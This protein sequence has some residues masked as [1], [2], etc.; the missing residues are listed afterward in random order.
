M[1]PASVS[2]TPE[3]SKKRRKKKD[4][5]EEEGESIGEDDE[6]EEDQ[7]GQEEDDEDEDFN[8]SNNDDNDE[9][10][11]DSSSS[12]DEHDEEIAREDADAIAEA[13]KIVTS[14]PEF[15]EYNW[16]HAN[17]Y[18]IVKSH[19][20]PHPI[21][22]PSGL[23][24][25]ISIDDARV[26]MSGGNYYSRGSG[27]LYNL[28]LRRSI[29]VDD[30]KAEI[31]RF[32]IT[33]ARNSDE[34]GICFEIAWRVLR[35]VPLSEFLAPP[36]RWSTVPI[37][38]PLAANVDLFV[39]LWTDA[40]RLDQNDSYNTRDR[41][42][43]MYYFQM[44]IEPWIYAERNG[45]QRAAGGAPVDLRCANWF[46][47]LMY[48]YTFFYTGI[49]ARLFP[50]AG[51]VVP[52]GLIASDYTKERELA[53]F[54]DAQTRLRQMFDTYVRYSLDDKSAL[55]FDELSS[56]PLYQ[57]PLE[58]RQARPPRRELETGLCVQIDIS[59]D[60]QTNEPVIREI[61]VLNGF[62]CAPNKNATITRLWIS[63][64]FKDKRIGDAVGRVFVPPTG[65]TPWT[66]AHASESKEWQKFAESTA[67]VGISLVV[68]SVQMP[69]DPNESARLRRPL[70]VS[71]G[72]TR[73]TLPSRTILAD[74]PELLSPAFV[75][76]G[77]VVVYFAYR[78][79]VALTQGDV[80]DIL[81]AADRVATSHHLSFE[82]GPREMRES[83][84][85]VDTTSN[86]YASYNKLIHAIVNDA[87]LP[88]HALC[89]NLCRSL[90]PDDRLKQSTATSA[91]QPPS[92]DQGPVKFEDRIRQT[93]K[94]V[95]PL[96]N[97]YI[98]AY[99]SSA[100]T[101][102]TVDVTD[103]AKSE[104]QLSSAGQNWHAIL[105]A[106]MQL[107]TRRIV[108]GIPRTFPEKKTDLNRIVLSTLA[109]GPGAFDD[110]EL[111]KTLLRQGLV[112]PPTIDTINNAADPLQVA[113]RCL[114]I[115]LLFEQPAIGSH[116]TFMLR[117]KD[118]KTRNPVYRVGAEGVLPLFEEPVPESATV[119]E[120]QRFSTA[121]KGEGKKRL[122]S[123]IEKDPL[124]ELNRTVAPEVLL[125]CFVKS[126]P[127]PK[128]REVYQAKEQKP[129]TAAAAAK[130]EQERDEEEERRDRNDLLLQKAIAQKAK[131]RKNEKQQNA[132]ESRVTII[133]KINTIATAAR[134]RMFEAVRKKEKAMAIH[135]A[136]QRHE[137]NIKSI[138]NR[139]DL[140]RDTREIVETHYYASI[141]DPLQY[142]PAAFSSPSIWLDQLKKH[143]GTDPMLSPYAIV[144]TAMAAASAVAATSAVL[145]E[146][147]HTKRAL[148]PD[149]D[150]GRN[151]IAALRASTPMATCVRIITDIYETFNERINWK[152][153]PNYSA[154]VENRISDRLG[155]IGSS[156]ASVA[157]TAD[158]SNIV[159]NDEAKMLE[160]QRK[161]T[162]ST[163]SLSL[164][165]GSGGDVDYQSL[166]SLADATKSI[167]A[168]ERKIRPFFY[169]LAIELEGIESAKTDQKVRA[170]D[171]LITRVRDWL[172][173]PRAREFVRANE[174]KDTA[175]ALDDKSYELYVESTVG[176]VRRG[177]SLPGDLISLRAVAQLYLVRIVILYR[178]PETTQEGEAR[179][180][181]LLGKSTNRRFSDEELAKAVRENLI[182]PVVILPRVLQSSGVS[183]VENWY[184]TIYV[185]ALACTLP[186]KTPNA[187]YPSFLKDTVQVA[188]IPMRCLIPK[189][190]YAFDKLVAQR[191][192]E[193]ASANENIIRTKA[194]ESA[195]H[196]F[197]NALQKA[198]SARN[199]ASNDAMLVA[200]KKGATANPTEDADR[201][202]ILLTQGRKQA[203]DELIPEDDG[204]N[205]QS[206][207]RETAVSIRVWVRRPDLLFSTSP[208][209]SFSGSVNVDY[210]Y[211][212]IGQSGAASFGMGDMPQDIGLDVYDP[213]GFLV[214]SGIQCVRIRARAIRHKSVPVNR[215]AA[216][217]DKEKRA[218]SI[219]RDKTTGIALRDT[220]REL[221]PL[222]AI[223]E[224]TAWY[225]LL[226]RTNRGTETAALPMPLDTGYRGQSAYQALLEPEFPQ[227]RENVSQYF[228]RLV[229]LEDFYDSVY[230]YDKKLG[231]KASADNG[232]GED[233]DSS[234]SS[235]SSD[236]SSSSSSSSDVVAVAA[237]PSAQQHAEQGR[238]PIISVVIPNAPP[239]ASPPKQATKGSSGGSFLGAMQAKLGPKK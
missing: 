220:S 33:E 58:I 159:R 125:E 56:E 204:D 122:L 211:D 31:P 40:V 80:Y 60:R 181:A 83:V 22:G 84:G 95:A 197:T 155:F 141:K 52:R 4:E 29:R 103:D 169:T 206:D 171:N 18:L 195:K 121:L 14:G 137:A 222:Q 238:K 35:Y 186:S 112:T 114:S 54:P 135:A 150:V 68:D 231:K 201:V 142:A 66:R 228:N 1:L 38:N 2:V 27:R 162:T 62:S 7:E 225:S 192:I 198:A 217:Y 48:Y 157:V 168:D 224:R 75:K 65:D 167:D 15:Q 146:R 133:D 24:H 115:D 74:H 53:T 208:E 134:N 151:A 23:E 110:D 28:Y 174:L 207:K 132:T 96:S 199:I 105:D 117:N 119:V 79:P 158:V 90:P 57:L 176:T 153:E 101:V 87:K 108:C 55:S 43:E 20:I 147:T 81:T 69:V 19:A 234:S 214:R 47:Q 71:L 10:D 184:R 8:G 226:A 76:G 145:L 185:S 177:W 50:G 230:T 36:S 97:A 216:Y 59:T 209:E 44:F 140:S 131:Q 223:S 175:F 49:R 39:E 148:V 63:V 88:V 136:T 139:N 219:V 46:D 126:D 194:N 9:S 130:A 3:E 164:S 82:F 160:Q 86:R 152:T 102:T 113:S 203:E 221:T 16:K 202:K 37:A 120:H 165:S 144:E 235:D 188:W 70:S 34:L 190:S 116:T 172:L 5:N 193:A 77:Q 51:A 104:A 72:P 41:W 106:A 89:P 161:Q 32:L 92:A 94:D 200:L 26:L 128:V 73:L 45:S 215:I 11:E 127:S 78:D 196:A 13:E 85:A 91:G 189:T 166:L 183:A 210:M 138:R 239:T 124:V 236:D 182:H 178:T 61:H 99:D 232:N 237:S 233:D 109:E 123:F 179:I 107:M 154:D 129:L 25:G 100:P 12:A 30:P 205:E 17:N 21:P 149:T 118:F 187:V 227:P 213:H 42:A 67:A 111:S 212:G 173:W 191:R 180:A 156:N 143:F 170:T 229:A 6:N 98:I 163:D 93:L 218:F 64:G